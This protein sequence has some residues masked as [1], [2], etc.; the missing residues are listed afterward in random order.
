MEPWFPPHASRWT[1]G[2]DLTW[3][4]LFLRDEG[5]II[6]RDELLDYYVSG[7]RH[8]CSA[9]QSTRQWRGMDVPPRATVTYTYPWERSLTFNGTSRQVGYR[10]PKGSTYTYAWELEQAEGLTVTDGAAICCTQLWEYGYLPDDGTTDQY[11]SFALDRRHER[12][13]QVYW[14]NKALSPK[15]V[16]ELDGTDSAWWREQGEPFVWARSMQRPRQ[17]DL[18]QL[19]AGYQQGYCLTFEETTH[20][21]LKE[22]ALYGVV[23]EMSG[24]RTYSW[25]SD[26]STLPYGLVRE[27][28]ST[29]RDYVH[30]PTWDAALGTVREWK[31]SDDAVLVWEVVIPD[32]AP[33]L[34]EDDTPSL[35]PEPLQKYIRCYVLAQAFLRQGELENAPLAAWFELR[36]QRGIGLLK[37]LGWV[38]RRDRGYQREPKAPQGR[39]VPR[40]RLPST[41]PRYVGV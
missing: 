16:R 18:Y 26:D 27:M 28:S 34:T 15:S 3:C 14:D 41:F 30:Q 39:A 24:S 22:R 31:S 10:S 13:L 6:A 5:V 36:W 29:G 2:D 35:I 20:T 9:A 37:K 23:R 38:T 1:V 25:T 11:Y 12:I 17:F 19:Q 7:Y 21:G 33:Q 32:S 40:P 8:L 4:Q